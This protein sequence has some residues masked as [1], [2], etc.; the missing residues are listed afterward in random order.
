MQ[1]CHQTPPAATL[2][3]LDPATP[4]P[5]APHGTRLPT[6]QA[7][8]VMPPLIWGAAGLKGA[9]R[10]KDSWLWRHYLAPGAVTLITSQ[11]KA[12]K[13]TLASVLLSRMK[14]GGAMAGLAL[15]AGAAVVV[16]EES[17]GLWQGRDQ[18]LSF[19]DHIG[20]F[21]QPFPA[22]PR[23]HEWHAF[24]DGLVDLHA[25]RPYAL[26][27]IDPL[28]S[29]LPG[30]ENDAASM[31]DALMPLKRLTARGIAVLVLHHPAKGRIRVGQ[32]ARGSGALPGYVDILIEMLPYRR[33][34]DEDRR[35]RIY[36]FSRYPQTPRQL[37]IEWTED[38]T[39]YLAHGTFAEEDFNCHWQD[40]RAV[41]AQ[42]PHWLTRREVRSRW[43]LEKPPDTRSLIRWL[44]EAVKLGLLKKHGLALRNNPLRYWLPE[45]EEQW[46]SDCL[47]PLCM[48]DF[49]WAKSPPVAAGPALTS[50]GAKSTEP[51]VSATAANTAP[52]E[53]GSPEPTPPMGEALPPTPAP[54]APPPPQV[55][56]APPP[57][58]CASEPA[59]DSAAT[60]RPL[61]AWPLSMLDEFEAARA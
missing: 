2:S 11:W 23:R 19:G 27:I 28:A 5:A 50:D 57:P 26:L 4:A 32:A 43:L 14:T 35:R 38:G 8:F 13:T 17:A 61:R 59:A 40:L 12:G 15:S 31:L 39:D 16:T 41:F 56:C 37:V 10:P 24:I 1:P 46:R 47:A 53:P 29:F 45:K 25:R 20:W 60:K 9:A 51:S 6:P 34:S 21:S 54:V 58:A 48:P 55:D 42:A 22:K 52:P 7:S 30:N 49:P 44:E 3:T 36:A 18:Q 33:A